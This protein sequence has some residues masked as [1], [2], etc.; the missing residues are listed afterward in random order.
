MILLIILMI[1]SKVLCK[2]CCK[3]NCKIVLPTALHADVDWNIHNKFYLNVN[4]DLGVVDKKELNQN[5]IAN[6]EC[7]SRFESKWF[8]FYVPVSWITANKHR[9]VLGYAR[10]FLYRI[11]F[12]VI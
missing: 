10:E 3:W 11:W 2:Y 4:G 8:S 9:L 6:S 12:C 7:N 5:S 1:L